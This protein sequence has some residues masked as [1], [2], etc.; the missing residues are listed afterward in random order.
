MKIMTI[1]IAFRWGSQTQESFYSMALINTI[2][3]WLQMAR[4][5]HQK[6]KIQITIDGKELEA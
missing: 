2:K 4:S 6:N 1:T 5:A 3:A